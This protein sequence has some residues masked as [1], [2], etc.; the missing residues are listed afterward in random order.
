MSFRGYRG[1][2]VWNRSIDLV[3]HTYGL[4]NRLHD[5]APA[6][7]L[8]ELRRCALAIPSH[9]AAGYQAPSTDEYLRNVHAVQLLLTRYET[10]IT[11]LERLE[12]TIPENVN[13]IQSLLTL[14]AQLLQ[15]LERYLSSHKDQPLVS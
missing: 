6:E 13:E 7:I 4:T 10:Q 1:L 5:D 11:I 15:S 9:L 12:W 14:L 2:T 3:E 8:A